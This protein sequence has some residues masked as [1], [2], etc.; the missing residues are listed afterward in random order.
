MRKITFLEEG[1]GEEEEEVAA[2]WQPQLKWRINITL[3]PCL[4]EISRQHDKCEF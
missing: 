1:G 2:T 3:F 4:Q